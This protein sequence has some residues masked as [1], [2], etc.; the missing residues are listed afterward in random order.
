MFL[1][2]WEFLSLSCCK[3]CTSSTTSETKNQNTKRGKKIE[4]LH[5]LKQYFIIQEPIAFILK[6]ELDK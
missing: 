6:G 3:Y 4:G 5:Y 1:S 2:L